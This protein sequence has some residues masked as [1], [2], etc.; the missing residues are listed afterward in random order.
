VLPD[1]A[2]VLNVLPFLLGYKNPK[3]VE[4]NKLFGD[5]DKTVFWLAALFCLLFVGITMANPAAMETNFQALFDFFITN[6]GWLYLFLTMLFLIFCLVLAF[7]KYGQIRLGKDDEKP[8]FSTAAWFAMLFAAGMGIGLVF[9]GAAEPIYHFAGPPFADP[10]TKAA[11]VEAM[12]YSFFH[13]GLH[14]WACYGVVA[15]ALAYFQFRRGMPGLISSTFLP[16]LGE[17]GI[18]GGW[19]KTIDIFTIVVTLF[20]VATSLGLGAMQIT[21]GLDVVFGIP[22]STAVSITIIAVITVLFTISAVTGIK[23]GIKW[24][25]TINMWLFFFLML[26]VLFLG[27][28]RY[29]VNTFVETL[30]G[31]IQNILWMSFFTDSQGAVAEHAGWEWVGGW[32]VFYWAWWITWAPFV[33]SFIARIS[34]GR[35]I[36]EFVFGIL[37]APTLLC[38]IWFAI[39]GGTAIHVEL[40]GAGGVAEAT[41]ADVTTAIFVMFSNLP[42]SGL[43]SVVAMILTTIFFITSADSSTYVV[44]MMTSKGSLDPTNGLRVFW[45]IVAGSIAAMLLL[46]GGLS[47]VQTTAF[48]FGFPFMIIMVFMM[49]S[50]LKA[51]RE[52]EKVDVVVQVTQDVS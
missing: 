35:T 22:S 23:R 5:Y 12:R 4:M 19:G 45:G 40:F 9:W 36:K 25:S 6:L 41:F 26:A 43:L 24:L 1:R 17:K 51:F 21:T 42:A 31:Y 37:L 48:V 27:P 34:R 52:D 39:M 3:E 30:G 8:E 10:G 47:A 13:W 32:T 28:T 33:G 50:L 7:S 20:G 2:K 44:S 11:A 29:L 16:L 46:T 49:Y 14:P 18:N 15:M 38:M